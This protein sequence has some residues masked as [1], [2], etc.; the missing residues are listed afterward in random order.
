M[1]LSSVYSKY[2]QKSKVFLYP[3]LDIKRGSSVTPKETYVSWNKHYTSED[4][5]LICVYEKRK[6]D[7]Y[8]NFE[9]NI[10]LKHNRHFNEFKSFDLY[11]LFLDNNI[12][13][14][15]ALNFSLKTVATSM[16]KNKLITTCWDTSSICCNGLNAMYLA[17][18]L[19]K[20]NDHVDSNN[21]IMKEII[22][23]NII[24]CQVMWE[25]LSYLRNN[26]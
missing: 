20:N 5:K 1:A 25:M 7:E 3:L 22:K 19:Y 6:D 23:Y 2:F 16:Y 11:K 14:K 15:G 18:N 12:V 26:W 10:L 24:D 8:K 17:Y 9:K 4:M 21:N 13:V